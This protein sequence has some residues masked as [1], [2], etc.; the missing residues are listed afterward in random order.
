MVM[1][2]GEKELWAPG[3]MSTDKNLW[4]LNVIRGLDFKVKINRLQD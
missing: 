2:E 1:F 3:E 4:D